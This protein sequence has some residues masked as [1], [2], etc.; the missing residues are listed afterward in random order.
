MDN[1]GM[2]VNKKGNYAMKTAKKIIGIVSIVLFIL[3]SFQSCAAGFIDAVQKNGGVSGR[4]G[5]ALAI[6]MLIA[7][8]IGVAL[9]DSTGGTITAGCCYGVGGVIGLTN[10]GIY[11]DL[12][13][14]SIISIVFSI[15]FLVS[16]IIKK[17]DS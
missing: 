4:A 1:C 16:A 6:F 5:I 9:T 15:I 2:M 17:E 11:G 14:W 12:I 3:I 7:G 13:I 10:V 8:I